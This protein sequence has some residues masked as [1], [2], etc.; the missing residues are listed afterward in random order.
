MLED[1]IEGNTEVEEVGHF[2]DPRAGRAGHSSEVPKRPCRL[3]WRSTP[4][5]MSVWRSASVTP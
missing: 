3:T 5:R 1:G 2:V 4:K